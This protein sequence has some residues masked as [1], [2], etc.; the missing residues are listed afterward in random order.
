MIGICC[1]AHTSILSLSLSLISAF[2]RFNQLQNLRWIDF[3]TAHLMRTSFSLFVS[4]GACSR[5]IAL[6]VQLINLRFWAYNKNHLIW[7]QIMQTWNVWKWTYCRPNCWH[8]DARQYAFIIETTKHWSLC[9]SFHFTANA[10][11][12]ICHKEHKIHQN[13]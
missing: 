3:F 8:D 9:V 5:T 1:D 4:S 10:S 2:D 12:A 6:L 11:R 7:N 13:T